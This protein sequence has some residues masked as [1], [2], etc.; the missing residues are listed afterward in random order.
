MKMNACEVYLQEVWGDVSYEFESGLCNPDLS[1]LCSGGFNPPSEVFMQTADWRDDD[2][3]FGA[4][5]LIAAGL[6]NK[7]G[8]LDNPNLTA[9]EQASIQARSEDYLWLGGRADAD[10]LLFGEEATILKVEA[11]AEYEDDAFSSAVTLE[12]LGATLYDEPLEISVGW[13]QSVTFLEG[14]AQFGIFAVSAEMAGAI[15]FEGSASIDGLGL[16]VE[17]TPYAG[18]AASV[19]AG[20][21]IVCASAGVAADLTIIGIELPAEGQ[22]GI[23]GGDLPWTAQASLEIT[24]LDGSVYLY[25]DVCGLYGAEYELFSWEGA[26]IANV[27]ILDEEGCL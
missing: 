22:L 13:E 17:V 7:D 4:S 21:G 10:A 27:D 11:K 8:L 2:E 16:T 14:T 18:V 15:G 9:A 12:V 25:A 20:L 3:N 1:A 24:A 5:Y 26:P 23:S 19:N 6:I